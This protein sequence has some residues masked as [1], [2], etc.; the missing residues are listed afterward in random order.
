MSAVVAE[1]DQVQPRPVAWCEAG[2]DLKPWVEPEPGRARREAAVGVCGRALLDADKCA[3]CADRLECVDGNLCAARPA[4]R[5]ASNARGLEEA[6]LSQLVAYDHV[7]GAGLGT[8]PGWSGPYSAADPFHEPLLLFA[9]MAGI[10]TTLEFATCVLV[11]PQRQT[12]LVAKQVAE[13][14][15]L[16]SGRFRLGVGT[17][18][19]DVEYQALG[20]GFARRGARLEEQINVLRALWS[21]P[22]VDYTGEFHSIADAG[23]NPLPERS[24]PVWMGGGVSRSSLERIARLADGWMVPR[25]TLESAAV[26]A[27]ELGRL[28]AEY[29]R[30]PNSVGIEGR[31]YLTEI[32]RSEWRAETA[33]WFELG[34]TR[35][36][37]VTEGL[38]FVTVEQHIEALADVATALA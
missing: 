33:R 14:H 6:G 27:E 28:V 35:L 5:Q 37:V 16:S 11:L 10:T 8:R 26:K 21:C 9:Y 4:H 24:I 25:L 38:G 34:A 2:G 31:L 18:W 30:H 13:L 19:N 22:T 1:R 12:A 29:G 15:T 32:S 7:L 3:R 23:I 36:N 17:G 20:V